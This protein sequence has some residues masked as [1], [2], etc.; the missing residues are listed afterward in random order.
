MQEQDSSHILQ[1]G[2]VYNEPAIA[3]AVDFDK[4]YPIQERRDNDKKTELVVGLTIA[5]QPPPTLVVGLNLTVPR[6]LVSQL[7]CVTTFAHLYC[8]AKD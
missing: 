7:V 2:P 3:P 5:T 8:R 6:S 1:F 4:P